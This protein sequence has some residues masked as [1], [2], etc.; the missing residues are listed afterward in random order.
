MYGAADVA[1]CL[2]G[3]EGTVE[4]VWGSLT[5]HAYFDAPGMEVLGGAGISNDYAIRLGYAAL[6]GIQRG[7][8]LTVD[9][10]A[11]KVADIRAIDDGV[12]VRVG[13]RKV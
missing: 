13:L 1:L 4:V 7:D 11:Y 9:G 12:L 6:P 5:T 10:L 2:A 8:D 3:A